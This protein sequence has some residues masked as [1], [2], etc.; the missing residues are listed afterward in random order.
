MV[1]LVVVHGGFGDGGG[2][3]IG[4]SGGGG[5]EI[6]NLVKVKGL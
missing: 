2:S 3:G 6:E 1:V 5:G 4:N